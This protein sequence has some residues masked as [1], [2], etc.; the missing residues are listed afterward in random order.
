MSNKNVSTLISFQEQDVTI[1]W[2]STDGELA[3]TFK[4]IGEQGCLVNLSVEE[5]K[6]LIEQLQKFIS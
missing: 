1:G 2:T 4:E 6:Q 5:A 3:I